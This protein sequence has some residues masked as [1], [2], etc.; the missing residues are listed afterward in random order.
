MTSV[1][2]RWAALRDREAL[3]EV[4]N[5]AEQAEAER[6]EAEEQAL[7]ACV[8]KARE[9]E[10]YLA[11][12]HG[13]RLDAG[14]RDMVRRALSALRV[15]S[16]SMRG[17]VLDPHEAELARAVDPEGPRWIRVTATLTSVGMALAAAWALIV[18][19]P[20]SVRRAQDVAPPSPEAEAPALTPS[21]QALA[22]AHT[23]SRGAR[24]RRA[25]KLLPPST[26]LSQGDEVKA[27]EKPGCILVTAEIEACLAP[28]A[29]LHLSDLSAGAPALSLLRGR[30]TVRFVNDAKSTLKVGIGEVQVRVR[31]GVFG[32]ERDEDASFV[33]VRSLRGEASVSA[34]EARA[35]LHDSRVA[36]YRSQ[37]DALEVVDL[38]PAYAQRDWDLVQLNVTSPQPAQAAPAAAPKDAGP[39]PNEADGAQAAGA[40]APPNAAR[41]QLQQ[42]WELLKAE[43]W[44]E[45]AKAY[46]RIVTQHP[47]TEEAHVVLVRWGELLLER[48]GAPERALAAFERY[49]AEGGG[50]LEG[51]ARYGRI[52][53]FR[54]LS[55][56][57]DEQAAI[58]EFLRMHPTSA[59][60]SLLEQRLRILQPAP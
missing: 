19:E 52:T 35:E 57:Q 48:L 53:A 1:L 60:A 21:V 13:R 38:L 9:L 7:H 20:R 29:T 39:E 32:L 55:R 22:M 40:G 50:P 14:D 23:G 18:Y 51:E 25:G 10:Q 30:A 5:A 43:R 34:G 56:P 47:G 59:K 12:V 27:G 41:A 45:A 16:P 8:A 24:L 46:E 17:R 15:S 26:P 44:A 36:V 2:E 4:L 31:G 54:R 6:I 3:G 33:R 28:G 49:L 37:E 42:A 11:G 58:A